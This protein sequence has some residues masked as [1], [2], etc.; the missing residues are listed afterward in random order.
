M[1]DV[2]NTE[3]QGKTAW[4]VICGVSVPHD[5]NIKQYQKLA[6]IGL[7]NQTDVMTEKEQ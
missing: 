7:K 5:V 6:T 1:R 4:P 3:K 2:T